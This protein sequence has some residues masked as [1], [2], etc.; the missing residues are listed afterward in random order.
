MNAAHVLDDFLESLDHPTEEIRARLVH[1]TEI[2]VQFEEARKA[3]FK[4]RNLSLRAEEKGLDSQLQ[5]ALL[6]RTERDQHKLTALLHEK[7]SL[8]RR[9]LQ[10]VQSHLTRLEGRMRSLGESESSFLNPYSALIDVVPPAHAA[11]V[12]IQISNND[13]NNRRNLSQPRKRVALDAAE[14]I[15]PNEPVYC[16]CRQVSFGDMIA[17]DEASCTIEWFHYGCVGLTAPPEGRWFCSQCRERLDRIA[18]AIDEH[19]SD[20]SS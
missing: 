5:A 1:I 16:T 17:C 10:I 9:L 13:L 11:N 3:L 19:S 4:K 14:I 18:K 7:I 20:E 15:D 6:R 2:D 8:E 12:Q